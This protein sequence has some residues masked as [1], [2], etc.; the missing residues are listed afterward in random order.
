M[1]PFS[2]VEAI[3]MA[4]ASTADYKHCPRLDT[5]ATPERVL[6]AIERLKTA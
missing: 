6:M 3:S 4:I 2:V 1:L 5:P